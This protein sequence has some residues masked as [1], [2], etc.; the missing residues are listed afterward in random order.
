MRSGPPLRA[1]LQLVRHAD[2]L[3]SAGKAFAQPLLREQ[4]CGAEQNDVQAPV[5]IPQPL[6]RL[7]PI[8]GFLDP[9]D[10]QDKAAVGTFGGCPRLFPLNDQPLRVS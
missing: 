2:G 5:G 8:R 6:D 1:P 10:R 4:R 7:R 9:V 3:E